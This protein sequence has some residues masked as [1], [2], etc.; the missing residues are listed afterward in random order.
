MGIFGVFLIAILAILSNSSATALT[1]IQEQFDRLSCPMPSQSGLWNDTS[2][3]PAGNI[4][5]TGATYNWENAGGGNGAQPPDT[6]TCTQVHTTQGI[7]YLNGAPAVAIGVFYYIG[8]YISEL[9][10]NKVVAVFTLISFVLS[11]ANF[12]FLGYTIDDI[13]GIPL[14]FV[15]AI[16]VFSYIFIG[17]MLYKIITPFAG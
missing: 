6:L 8:D 2:V 3:I 11:P 17:A 16:Y 13:V 15:I 5:Y 10:A 9:F 7:D 1:N 12:N 4:S 14:M